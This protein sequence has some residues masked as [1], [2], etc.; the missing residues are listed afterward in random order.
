MSIEDEMFANAIQ[1]QQITRT[2]DM[3]ERATFPHV[4]SMCTDENV[5]NEIGYK[6]KREY[7]ESLN[8]P[9]LFICKECYEELK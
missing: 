7:V 4:C 9:Y 5:L 6:L 3:Y 2:K 8:T 1:A